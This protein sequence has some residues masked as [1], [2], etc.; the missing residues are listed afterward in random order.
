MMFYLHQ[1][2][3]QFGPLNV[4]SYITFR[5]IAAAVTAFVI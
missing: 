2:S 1:L 5:A 3:S 4:F